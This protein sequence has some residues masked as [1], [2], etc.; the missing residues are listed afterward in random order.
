MPTT[1]DFKFRNALSEFHGG[2]R[3]HVLLAMM[4]HA[5]VRNRCWPSMRG[6]A[7]E[8]GYALA[9][10]NDAKNWLEE[11]GAIEIVKYEQR[12]GE[13]KTPKINHLVNVY[14]L[15]GVIK[16]GE[17][18]YPVLYVPQS[19]TSNVYVPQNE[20]SRNETLICDTEVVTSVKPVQKKEE[21]KKKKEKPI[22]SANAPSDQSF[23]VQGEKQKPDKGKTKAT[24]PP[25]SA[26]PPKDK[27]QSTGEKS[28]LHWLIDDRWTNTRGKRSDPM[29]LSSRLVPVLMGKSTRVDNINPA[30]SE[31]EIMAFSIWYRET[32]P[33]TSLPMESK[34]AA[35]FGQFRACPD[36][37]QRL[38]DAAHYVKH[39]YHST[40]AP[41]AP[42]IESAPASEEDMKEAYDMMD[43]L[44]RKAE[45][46]L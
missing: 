39:I 22:E 30:A 3:L 19:D 26:R 29:G 17:I 10:V 8:T 32:H 6:L 34:L 23:S 13:E 42:V 44:I 1:F 31:D 25:S 12:I 46:G 15:T 35:W 5:N 37:V 24:T 43:E 27:A 38:K 45:A 14:Q 16:F 40:A 9:A 18:T 2:A 41:A 21:N 11:H 33:N 4:L 20:T 36:Y 28:I 7:K